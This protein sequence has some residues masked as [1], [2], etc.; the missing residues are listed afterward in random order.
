MVS[1]LLGFRSLS[2]IS[3]KITGVLRSILWSF[4]VFERRRPPETSLEWIKHQL[5]MIKWSIFSHPKRTHMSSSGQNESTNSPYFLLSESWLWKSSTQK[6][7]FREEN[8]LLRKVFFAFPTG[9]FQ[10]GFGLLYQ[11][12]FNTW[13][14]RTLSN[15]WFPKSKSLT[16]FL[17]ILNHHDIN[18]LSVGKLPVPHHSFADQAGSS[19]EQ[20]PSRLWGYVSGRVVPNQISRRKKHAKLCSSVVY[21]HSYDVFVVEVT[22]FHKKV[23]SP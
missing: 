18:G 20:L 17:Q 21:A 2:S 16:P 5:K 1:S 12:L 4:Q 6:W 14:Q 23:T 19:E 13:S 15:A 10:R 9:L 22:M 11:F 8:M 3:D 7:H